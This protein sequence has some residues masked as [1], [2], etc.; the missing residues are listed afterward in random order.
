MTWAT[1]RRLDYVDWRLLNHGS[2]QRSDIVRTFD[3][4]PTQASVDL[5]EFD[6][7]HPGAMTY[8]NSAAVRA[9]V[10]ANG[11]YRSQRG[12]DAVPVRRALRLLADAGHPMGWR[13]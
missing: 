6:R 1:D 8:D 11:R 5:R 12:M 3:V 10:P 2:V 9:Y 13:E 4:S 7:A